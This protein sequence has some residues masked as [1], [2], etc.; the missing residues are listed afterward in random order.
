MFLNT[1][2]NNFRSP[3]LGD[4]KGFC[5]KNEMMVLMKELRE[6]RKFREEECKRAGRAS[7]M[8]KSRGRVK[9]KGPA[10][11]QS[12]RAGRGCGRGDSS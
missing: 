1:Y 12:D 10:G 11:R 6:E 3:Q 4:V 7:S 2:T 5:V 9:R 8:S